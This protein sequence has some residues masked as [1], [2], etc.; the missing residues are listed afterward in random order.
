MRVEF[1]CIVF[2]CQDDVFLAAVGSLMCARVYTRSG[3]E[4]LNAESTTLRSERGWGGCGKETEGSKDSYCPDKESNPQ[5]LDSQ[6]SALN[7]RPRLR[8]ELTDQTP[9]LTAAGCAES[10]DYFT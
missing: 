6:S 8:V 1:Q 10:Y 4:K 2:I 3:L 9:L 5:A 7:T